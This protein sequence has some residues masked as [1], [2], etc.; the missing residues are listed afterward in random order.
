MASLGKFNT[1]NLPKPSR[2]F[3]VQRNPGGGYLV[4]DPDG[5][6]IAKTLNFEDAERMRVHLQAKADKAF[7]SRERACLCCKVSFHSEGNH[8]R[9]C[10]KCRHG[11]DALQ[12]VRPYIVRQA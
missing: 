1:T 5:N 6:Q 9:L 7:N 2:H 4:F 12:P 3:C 8:N 11:S 10:S